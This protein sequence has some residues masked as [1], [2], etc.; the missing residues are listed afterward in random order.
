MRFCAKRF[1]SQHEVQ[2][3]NGDNETDHLLWHP[4][5]AGETAAVLA[6]KPIAEHGKQAIA[7]AAIDILGRGQPPVGAAGSRTGLAV[8]YVQSGKTLSFTIVLAL[9]RDNNFPVVIVVA[10]TS[11]DLFK[12]TNKRLLEDLHV[13][14]SY[15]PPRWI[16]LP[17]PDIGSQQLFQT[18]LENWRDEEVLPEEKATLLITVAKQHIRLRNL[19]ALLAQFDLHDVPIV[20]IDDE[21]DQ[22]SLNAKVNDG[23]ETTTYQRL[24]ELRDRLPR[25]TFLQYTATPQAPLLINIIDVL[26]PEYVEV[27]EPGDGYV[28]GQDFFGGNRQFTRV[29]PPEEIPSRDNQFDEPPETL[30]Q[31]LRVFFMGVTAAL[32]R[33]PW[34]AANQNRSML[35]HPTRTT[36][37]HFQYF[38]AIQAI[39]DE[40]VRIL[41]LNSADPDRADLVAEFQ[42][43]YRDLEATMGAELPEFVTIMARLRRNIAAVQIREVNRRAGN[44]TRDFDWRQS[45]AWILVGGQAM[46]RGFTVKDLTVTYMPRGIGTGNAD[47]LQQRARFFGYKRQ[48]LGS[49]RIYLEAEALAS[50]EGYVAHEE[51]MREELARLKRDGKA[52]KEWK[53]RFILSADLQPCRSS[54]IQQDI[55]RGNYSDSWY[56]PK[57]PRMSPGAIAANRTLFDAVQT[58]F[59]FQADSEFTQ[60]AQQHLKCEGAPLSEVLDELLFKYRVEDPAD[61]QNMLGLLLQLGEALK[62][63]G[64]E[65]VTIYRMRPAYVGNRGLE[66][67][68]LSSIRRLHQGPTRS[69]DGYSYPGDIAFKD[70]DSISIQMHV[71]NLTENDAVVAEQVPILAIWVPERLEVDWIVQ[72]QDGTT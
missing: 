38:Q 9:A 13:E 27:L 14:D 19:N 53:R 4:S 47:T 58:R 2:M 35:V 46:D 48:Y 72:D 7:R 18:I 45:Y 39:K 21:A 43:T 32:I 62:R 23:D 8:G 15:G 67:D 50:F 26:S 51:A 3:T 64:E 34:S 65:T 52:L 60:P 71:V 16:H 10:G 30:L 25:H 1:R 11:N 6:P 69:D 37:E 55:V 29:I 40:W 54:V 41:G 20:V 61:T 28:G 49:C 42:S 22:A 63:N 5:A 56:F 57:M 36:H 68:R 12:Q 59:Q 33:T 17:N 66:R 70:D 44:R 31:A 24:L